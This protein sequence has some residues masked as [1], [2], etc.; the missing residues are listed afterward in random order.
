MKLK[1]CRRSNLKRSDSA[2]VQI[3]EKMGS[4]GG[5]GDLFAPAVDTHPV[6]KDES[7]SNNYWKSSISKTKGKPGKKTASA[8]MIIKDS[9]VCV[10]GCKFKARALTEKNNK[11]LVRYCLC[12]HLIQPFCVNEDVD[13]ALKGVWCCSSCRALLPDRVDMPLMRSVT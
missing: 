13:E 12:M 7:Q 3:S 8:P 9:T 1:A 11:D 5:D 6:V 2:S 10:Q 4:P